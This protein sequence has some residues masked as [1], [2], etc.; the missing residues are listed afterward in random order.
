MSWKLW[1]LLTLIICSWQGDKKINYRDTHSGWKNSCVRSSKQQ[2]EIE[3]STYRVEFCAIQ[4]TVEEVQ[5]VRYML[6]CLGVKV[7][8]ASLLCG[9]N[10]GVIQNC[11]MSKSLLKKKHVAIAFHKTREASIVYPIKT[12]GSDNYSDLLTKAITGKTFWK[13]YGG[14]TR[15]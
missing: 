2:G 3:T 6:C 12:K 10:L 1:H 4:S 5:S 11:T 15:G 7:T 8:R 14:L 9:D 13:L